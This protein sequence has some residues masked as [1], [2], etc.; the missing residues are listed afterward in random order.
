M[1]PEPD[2][3]TMAPS[4][5]LI[6]GFGVIWALIGFGLLPLVMVTVSGRGWIPLARVVWL[7]LPALVLLT[8]LRDWLVGNRIGA[9]SDAVV[10]CGVALA[11]LFITGI[12]MTY[13]NLG[14]LPYAIV[15]ALLVFT[16]L[17][18][19]GVNHATST[20]SPGVAD[21]LTLPGV[22]WAIFS[23]TVAILVITCS[24]LVFFQIMVE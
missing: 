1:M 15:L 19:W 21:A 6:I 17:S 7:I 16:V 9:V 13:H 12:G 2:E 23:A 18:F 24:L 8:S 11:W 10:S 3:R 20:T 4:A 14:V 5:S 22:Y